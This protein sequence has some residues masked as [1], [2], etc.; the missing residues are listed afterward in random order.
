VAID[1]H[2]ASGIDFIVAAIN[3]HPQ[4]LPVPPTVE[5]IVCC[6]GVRTEAAGFFA[7]R[8]D[9]RVLAR[10][11]ATLGDPSGPVGLVTLMNVLRG[12]VAETLQVK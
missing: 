9:L 5:G 11:V 12:L 3:R 4:A 8:A 2:N 10:A 6:E 1:T 7:P